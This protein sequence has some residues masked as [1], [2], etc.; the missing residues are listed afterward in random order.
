[1]AAAVNINDVLA[2]HIALEIECVDR[3]LLNAYVPGL[4][5]PGQVV[6]FLTGHRGHPIPSPALLGQIGNRFVGQVKAFAAANG[7][8]LLR[9]GV[10]DRSRWDD[11][12]LDHVRPYLEAAERD[13]RFGV[14]AIV[15]CQEFAH[16]YSARN[17]ATKPGAVSF[18]FFIER[19][20]VGAYYFYLHDREFGPA[21]IKICTYFPYPARVW[22]N[23]HEWSKRQAQRAGLAFEALSNGFRSCPEPAR[24]QAVCDSLGPD[25]VQ[26]F[27]DRA[28]SQIPT[29]LTSADRAAGYW[30]ELSMRQVEVSRT[31]V[32]DD[33]RRARAFFEA[34]V[35]DNVGIGRPEEVSVVFARHP[36]PRRQR[37]PD[38]FR[39]RVFSAG[40]DVRIDFRYKNSRVKQYLK[41]GRALRVETVI[42][43]PDDVGVARRL[44]HLPELTAKA[45][46]VNQRLLMIER[47]GQ[48]CAIGSA[49]FERIHLPYHHEGQRTGALRFGDQRAMALAGALHLVL[50][51]VTGFTNKSLRAH[52]A[53]LL[54]QDYSQHQMSYDLRRLR[55]H[56]LI[57]RLPR[58]NTYILTPDG[59]RVAVFYTKLQNRLLRP[60]LDAD[61][62][63][64]RLDIRHALKTLESAVRDYIAS[65][66]L[67]PAI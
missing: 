24:L 67:A 12:K 37:T 25:D 65:A 40:T 33:P 38:Q 32:L 27:V 50:N 56:G 55:L 42:N 44:R 16:V 59:I 8:P 46:Q 21:F 10:P 15:A 13:G 66:R 23:G 45:R 36:R 2:G 17:R 34:L 52:V 26:A 49:L 22:V 53:G 20:R 47:A 31:L 64:A 7:I 4:Q 14:V 39:T 3:M 57:E 28:L 54:G 11:R 5:M 48:S 51:A 1:M 35:S 63:P 29:P 30:W 58:S 41:D 18:E 6:R 62:P 61:K 43:K 19:R 60:L 9:L